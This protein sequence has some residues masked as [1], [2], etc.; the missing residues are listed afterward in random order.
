LPDRLLE[1]LKDAILKEFKLIWEWCCCIIKIGR[2]IWNR[3]GI[4]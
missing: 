4:L 3:P 1:S 2:L